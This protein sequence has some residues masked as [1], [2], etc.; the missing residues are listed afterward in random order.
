MKK[1]QMM[2]G[3]LLLAVLVWVGCT[4]PKT[5]TGT[6]GAVQ[7]GQPVVVTGDSVST[8]VY[9]GILPCADCPG[10]DTTLKLYYTKTTGGDNRFELTEVYIDR[11]TFVT[12][13]RFNTERGYGN[14]ND[15]TVIVLNYDQPESEQSYYMHYSIQPGELHALTIGRELHTDTRMNYILK[16]Q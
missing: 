15:A 1:M 11:D 14:D 13:G 16:K 7:A 9:K 4:R 2:G 10:I 5:T 6:P 3:L 8:A 12:S